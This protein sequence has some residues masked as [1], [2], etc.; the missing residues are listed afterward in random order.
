MGIVPSTAWPVWVVGLVAVPVIVLLRNILPFIRNYRVAQQMGLPVIYS[1]VAQNNPV[2]L[3]LGSYL[4]P[5]IRKAPFGLGS[6]VH[7]TRY[8]WLWEDQDQMHQKLGKVFIHVNPGSLEVRRQLPLSVRK[9]TP[10]TTVV[11]SRPG[12]H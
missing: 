7:Y 11:Y 12:S 2:W 3:V 1:P 10:M 5:L 6:W 4:G 8:M 9:L